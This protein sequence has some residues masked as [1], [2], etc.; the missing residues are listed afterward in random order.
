MGG[1]A[2]APAERH[3]IE[4]PDLRRDGGIDEEQDQHRRE[5]SEKMDGEAPRLS[6]DEDALSPSCPAQQQSESMRGD[7]SAPA[8]QH[9]GEPERAW[10]EPK[11]DCSADQH[12]RDERQKMGE[13]DTHRQIFEDVFEHGSASSA[14]ERQSRLSCAMVSP[15][16]CEGA[17]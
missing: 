6:V 2:R 1:D 15:S 7:G 11:V 4:P 12:A 9:P 8:D 13:E 10:R 16:R 3:P 14:Q 17:N 5:I